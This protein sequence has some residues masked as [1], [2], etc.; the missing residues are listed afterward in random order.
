MIRWHHSQEGKQLFLRFGAVLAALVAAALVSAVSAEARLSALAAA[1]TVTRVRVTSP[2]SAGS[3]ATLTVRV[4]R[5]AT[6]SI[7]VYYYSGP[8]HAAGLYPKR[9]RLI[10]WTWKVGTRT[11]PGRWPIVVNCG[12]AGKL[13]T[14]FVVT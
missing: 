4:S 2:I 6:C 3:Y 14:S 13:R 7:T 8:S 10:S 11:T 5:T 9:G 1:D 12:S